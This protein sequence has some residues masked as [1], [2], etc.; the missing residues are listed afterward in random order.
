MAKLQVIFNKWID[1]QYVLRHEV[2]Y[3]NRLNDARVFAYQNELVI[4]IIDGYPVNRYDTY[5]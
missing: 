4:S 5:L 2:R 1:D 3:F